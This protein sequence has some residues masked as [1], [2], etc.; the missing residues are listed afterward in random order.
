MASPGRHCPDLLSLMISGRRVTPRAKRHG[1][2]IEADGHEILRSAVTEV[3]EP[4]VPLGNRNVKHFESTD[5][6][7]INPW[8]K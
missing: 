6:V 3:A 5:T 4:S 2:S 7:I 8:D 1:H